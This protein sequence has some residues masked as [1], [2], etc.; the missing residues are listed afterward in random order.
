MFWQDLQ[1]NETTSLNSLAEL[2]KREEREEWKSAD[3]QV[4]TGNLVNNRGLFNKSSGH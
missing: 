2:K 3:L 4:E 1:V